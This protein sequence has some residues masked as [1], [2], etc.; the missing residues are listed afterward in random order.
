MGHGG[1]RR[2]AVRRNGVQNAP[3]ELVKAA[4]EEGGDDNITAVVASLLGA[5]GVPVTPPAGAKRGLPVPLLLGL[6]LL[7]LV[8]A[9]A[10]YMMMNGVGGVQGATATEVVAVNATE[11]TGAS[12]STATPEAGGT[13]GDVPPTATER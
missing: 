13:T 1:A 10:I 7:L 6:V 12:A 2:C 4:N 8:G 9:G 3:T 11:S 5:G